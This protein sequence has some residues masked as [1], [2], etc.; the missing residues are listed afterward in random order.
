MDS[1]RYWVQEVHIDGFRFDLASVLGREPNG[2]DP[3]GGFFDAIRQDPVLA[4]V[5]LIAEPWDI[6]PGGYQLGAYP[7]PFSE[8]NDKYRDGVRR[9]WRN[10]AGLAP[11]FSRRLLGSADKFDHSRRA[12]TLFGELSS[13]RMMASRWKIWSPIP[14]SATSPMARITATAMTT[15]TPT[16]W[17]L[18]GQALIRR[19]ARRAI[20]ASATCSRR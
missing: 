4:R 5:K 12:A 17:A 2:F 13:P 10:D 1:L 20:C 11:E 8:W 14:S 6:G 16:I 7:A 15:T 18:R 19:S 9:F 3:Q